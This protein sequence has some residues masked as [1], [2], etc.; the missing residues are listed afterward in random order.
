MG[1]TYHSLHAST[2]PEND[3]LGKSSGVGVGKRKKGLQLLTTMIR[4]IPERYVPPH[5]PTS[6]SK[7]LAYLQAFLSVREIILAVAP[8]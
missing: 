7:L 2:V 4:V 3:S 6:S 8:M 1:S 5:H